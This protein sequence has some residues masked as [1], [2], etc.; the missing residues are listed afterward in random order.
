LQEQ[1]ERKEMRRDPFAMDVDRERN[2]YSYRGFGH[3]MQNCRN[4]EIVGQ[5]RKVEYGNNINIMNNL[6]EEESLVVLSYALTIDS[7]Y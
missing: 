7:I 1:E 2:C 3:I 5:R 4:Q 6:K